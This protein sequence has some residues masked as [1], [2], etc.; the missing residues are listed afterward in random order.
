MSVK[1]DVLSAAEG[2]KGKAQSVE[3]NEKVFGVGFNSG[4][5]HQIVTAYQLG[6]R[7]GTRAQ[8]TRAEISGGGSKPFAQKGTGQARAGTA[9]SPLWRKGGRIFAAKPQDFSQ[10]VNKKMKRQAMRSIYSELIR[11]GRLV[12]VDGIDLGEPK[13]KSLVQKLAQLK[14]ADA[15]IVVKEPNKN[16]TLS[17]RN[18]PGVHVCDAGRVDPVSLIRHEKVV[19]TVEAL[20]HVEAILA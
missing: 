13:T 18:L 17:A 19:M 6:G 16:L 9:R 20:K 10:K 3:L 2:G 14:A 5:V 11:E 7:Q 12:A 15:L 1:I 4:L 8:K